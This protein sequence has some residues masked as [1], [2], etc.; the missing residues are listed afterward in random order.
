MSAKENSSS[1]EEVRLRLDELHPAVMNYLIRK[2]VLSAPDSSWGFV[3]RAKKM[4][5]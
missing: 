1:K 3:K 2:G 5:R 4:S